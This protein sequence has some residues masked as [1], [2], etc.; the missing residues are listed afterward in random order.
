MRCRAWS[1]GWTTI[2]TLAEMVMAAC[3]MVVRFDGDGDGDG[4]DNISF[5]R[6]RVTDRE[7]NI[8]VHRSTDGQREWCIGRSIQRGESPAKTY[9]PP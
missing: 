2:L 5:W 7:D 6:E 1:C 9:L 4:D 8:M 3:C